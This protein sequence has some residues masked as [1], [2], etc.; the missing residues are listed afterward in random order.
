[1]SRFP[2]TLLLSRSV[3][4]GPTGSAVIVGNLARVFSPEEMVILGAYYLGSPAVPWQADWATLKYATV[5]PPDGWRGARWMR[6]AQFPW[7]LLRTWWT[8]IAGR[9]KAILIIYPDEIFLLAAYLIARLTRT[10]LLAYFHNTY[11][12]NRGHSRFARWLQDRVFEMA[13]HVFVMSEG[14][15]RLY[16]KN[17]PD[18]RCSPLLHSF[19]EVLPQ[20]NEVVLPPLHHPL[21]LLLFG[22]FSA[23]N[24]DAA[25]RLAELVHATPDVHLTLLSGTD[26]SYLKR[27]GLTGERISVET[28]TREVLLERLSEADLVL[29]PHGFSGPIADEEIATI[30]P[31]RTIEALISQRPILAHAP[32]NCFLTEF[33]VSFDCALVVDEPEVEALKQ[34]LH[35]LCTDAEL[36]AHLVTQ[37][38]KAARQF[39]SSTVGSELRRVIENKVVTGPAAA[40]LLENR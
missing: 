21:R 29:L 34:A 30:F 5:H 28:V 18:L 35:L 9:C 8:L 13:R 6:W 33:L 32:R 10:P 36:R 15:R 38:L 3:P 2:K 20:E 25:G 14:M 22:N 39:H 12:E 24:A 40:Q 19:T 16:K 27:L 1:M 26:P 7:L 31:T 23:S 37:A 4:P 11:L 17:Y